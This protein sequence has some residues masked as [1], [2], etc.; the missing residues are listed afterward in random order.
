MPPDY[1]FHRRHRSLTNLILLPLLWLVLLAAWVLLDAAPLLIGILAACTAPLL[2]DLIRN[3]PAGLTL[4]QTHLAWHSGTRTAEIAIR[5]IA[6]VRLDT[7]LDF[8]V[9]ATV[10][11]KSGR[12]LRIPFEATPRHHLFETALNAQDIPT[13]RHHFSLRQ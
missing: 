11:L 4:T 7:R 6:R 10:V 13:E 12:A 1:V 2:W 9:R 8:S 3:P 5:E